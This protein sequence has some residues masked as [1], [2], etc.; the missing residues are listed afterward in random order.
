MMNH[1]ASMKSSRTTC[2]LSIFLYALHV[3]CDKKLGSGHST[4]SY[5]ISLDILS[6][7]VLNFLN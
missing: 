3:F 4:K 6:I 7:L 5:L 2:Y 1:L